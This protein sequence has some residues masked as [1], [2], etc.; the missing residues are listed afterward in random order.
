MYR[1]LE[2]LAIG[3]WWRYGG[4]E[5]NYGGHADA[6]AG[7]ISTGPPGRLEK[8]PGGREDVFG[9]TSIDLRST[10]ALMKFLKLAVDFESHAVI[11]E[12]WGEKPFP[13][14]LA[15]HV[16]VPAP[17]QAPLLA[18]TLSPDPYAE[19]T[20]AYALP[21]I[22]RHL[23]SIGMFGPGFGSLV[24]RWGGLAEVAQVAC[25]ALAV[26]GGV[27]VLK[28][29]VESIKGLDSR[30]LNEE[31]ANELAPSLRIHLEGGEEIKAHWIVGSY[32]DLPREVQPLAD[33]LSIQVSHSIS[34][35]SSLL[36]SL[37]PFPSEGSP[38][39][40]GALV[41]FP[42]GSLGSEE[43]PPVYLMVHS[44]DTGECPTGQCKS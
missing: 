44:S 2:F 23:T 11:L 43:L 21:R 31:P 8:I 7:L 6:A 39:P 17:L 1:H 26:G 29:G 41:V 40:A 5:E 14:F 38:P 4:A 27:Y 12:E 24:P 9:D 13:D 25:R 33:N 28:K 36:S 3:S 30:I 37:F 20:T 19:T 15:T 16:K 22:Y 10:R 18:L 34:I 42:T 35:V 32:Y